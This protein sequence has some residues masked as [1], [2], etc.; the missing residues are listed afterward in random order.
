MS[1]LKIFTFGARYV[2]WEIAP[3]LL[4]DG[5]IVD[6]WGRRDHVS[7]SMPGSGAPC[8][9]TSR[10]GRWRSFPYLADLEG[11]DAKTLWSYLCWEWDR[12]NNVSA[13]PGRKLIRFN[14]FM[15]QA[16]V[17]PNMGFSSTRK[18]LIHS[19]EC[20]KDD[21]D[22]TD[23]ATTVHSKQNPTLS[24]IGMNNTF[25]TAE[26]IVSDFN[27]SA[28]EDN[29]MNRGKTIDGING[30]GNGN[31][32]VDN[33]HNRNNDNDK[34]LTSTKDDRTQIISDSG[35]KDEL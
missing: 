2:T 18:R 16:D 32:F 28:Q 23:S 26:S 22:V 25:S 34:E 7:W 1:P 21:N 19:H 13:N 4:V 24:D 31:D 3:G 29:D 15:L 14:F 30:N 6:V 8:T 11:D 35:N 9:S 10:P 27:S 33:N 12:N 5:S 17:L 20:V